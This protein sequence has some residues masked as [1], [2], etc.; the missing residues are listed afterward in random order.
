MCGILCAD[1]KY[2][3]KFFRT[4]PYIARAAACPVPWSS[5]LEQ[6]EILAAPHPPRQVAQVVLHLA[7]AVALLGMMQLGAGAGSGAV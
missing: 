1:Q 3:F 5:S 2:L 7:L 4:F 6:V